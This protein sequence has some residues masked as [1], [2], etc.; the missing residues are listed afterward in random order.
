M[1][2]KVYVNGLNVKAITTKYGELLKVGIKTEKLVEFLVRN[3]NEKGYCNIDILR[4]KAPDE[5]GNTHY[6]I[7]NEYEKD[8][9]ANDIPDNPSG[10]KEPEE[11]S[12]QLHF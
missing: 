11:D 8:L 6:A 10:K 9:S 2:E 1:S 12:N 4:K 7:L 5:Y 3:T